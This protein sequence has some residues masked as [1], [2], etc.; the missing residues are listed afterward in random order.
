V[1]TIGRLPE[2]FAPVLGLLQDDA[3]RYFGVSHLR[4]VPAQLQERPFSHVLRV[5]VWRASESRA[6]S[7]L[8]VKL[9]K[10]KAIAGDGDAMRKRVTRDYEAT[11]R[12]HAWF[13]PHA[14]L[15]AV[16]PVACYP[17][18]LAL[19]TEEVAGPTL[20]DYLETN[21]AWFPGQRRRDTLIG[22]ARRVGEWVRIFQSMDVTDRVVT[23]ESFREYIDI[24]LQRL[25]G[26]PTAAFTS[27]DRLRVLDTIERLDGTIQPED[28]R[29]VTIHADL[30]LGNVLVSGERIVV[31]DFA[32]AAHGTS[33]HDLTRLCLQIELL[34]IKPH[35]STRTVRAVQ[36][37]LLAGFDPALT[38][39]RPLFRLLTL[40]HRVN[41]LASVSVNPAH[42]PEALYNALVR[43][44]HRRWIAA[45]INRAHIGARR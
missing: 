15:G 23:V 10:P 13:Q 32:M 9:F 40:L 22:T 42:G 4:L 27:D 14:A 39:E 21:A 36:Q 19:V 18:Q 37:A 12:A 24:R 6:M 38:S 45:E 20:L 2:A 26:H 44:Q 1:S 41:H 11:R 16:A 31:L 8:F 3:E 29:E 34:A 28:L 7:H 17:D 30:S 43:R 5:G 33:L 25:V 35:I